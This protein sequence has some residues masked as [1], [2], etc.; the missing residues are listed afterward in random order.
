MLLVFPLHVYIEHHGICMP[1]FSHIPSNFS[2]SC[3]ERCSIPW[4]ANVLH[5]AAEGDDVYLRRAG[6]SCLHFVCQY[7]NIV[8]FHSVLYFA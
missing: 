7:F 2:I 5:Y 6:Y 4:L 1:N 3:F 8:L